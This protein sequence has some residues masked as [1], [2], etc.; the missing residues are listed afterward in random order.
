MGRLR[1]DRFARVRLGERY[2]IKRNGLS[3]FGLMFVSVVLMVLSRVEH[4][5]AAGF[6]GL[7]TDTITPVLETLSG[8][9]MG[10]RE[11]LAHFLG[12]F[13]MPSEIER[14]R[15]ENA[16]LR[17][18]DWRLR[19]AETEIAHYRSLLR[20]IEEPG[21]NYVTGRIVTDGQG[22]FSRSALLNI[23]RE[24]GL[25]NGFAVITGEGMIGRT[26]DVGEKAARVLLVN[27]L[28]SRIPVLVGAAGVRAILAGDN[29][30]LLRLEFVPSGTDVAIG[31]EVYTSGQDGI[32]PPGLRIGSVRETG[33]R[34]RVAPHARLSALG[35]V[36]VLF[37]QTPALDLANPLGANRQDAAVK[38]EAGASDAARRTADANRTHAHRTP[39]NRATPVK[40][41]LP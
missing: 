28:N 19:Q 20:V 5:V 33:P 21:L 15:A 25:R 14:L 11:N 32:L 41:P 40:E 31:D 16:R 36:S 2:E 22:P 4:P 6:R 13:S 39:A 18:A 37:L 7:L 10:A 23:G 3:L 35:P 29:S 38:P 34:P 8:P 9:V 27:D 17:E 24:Q 1:S 30:E 12:Y 26:L